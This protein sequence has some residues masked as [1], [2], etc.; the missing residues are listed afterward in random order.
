MQQAAPPAQISTSPKKA[1]ILWLY[2]L[3]GAGKTTLAQMAARQL[4]SDGRQV[5]VLDGDELRAGLCQGLGYTEEA[6]L[7]NVRRAAEMAKL[8]SAQGC[9]VLVALMTPLRA[10]RALAR[11]ILGDALT[12]LHLRCDPAVCAARD[13]KGLYR[14]AATGLITHLPGQDMHFETAHEC[15]ASLDT[16]RLPPEEC[17]RQ[18]LR[19]VVE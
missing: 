9:L 11:Q 12:T 13:V 2:G 7:E 14:Q 6:R 1:G 19:L 4:R 8:L 10:M 17:L 18:L 5:V 15:E 16:T 3:S